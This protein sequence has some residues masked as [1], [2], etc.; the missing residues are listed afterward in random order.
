MGGFFGTVSKASCVTD[1]F[2]GTDYNS[3]LGTKRGGLATYDAEEG[4]FARS[5]HNLESTY[6]RTKFEDELDKF[7][8]NVGIGI[9][10]D[11]DPQPIIINSHLGRFAIVTVAKIVNLEEIEAELLSQ[12]MH[13]AELSSGNTNQTELISL[14]IIQGKTFVE[15]IENVYR[16]VKGSCSMLLLSEDGS[17]I[18]ARDKWGRTPI[19][20]GW[21]EGAYAATSESSSFPN[22][23][24]EIDRYLGPGEIVRMTADGVE[25]LRKPEEKMQ[26]CSFLWVYYGFP[27][28]C[29]EGRNVEEV[30]FTSGLKMGQ[31]DDSEVDCACGIPDSGVGM[32]LGYAEGK[33]VPYHRAIS[34]YTPTWPRSFTP[35]KQEMRSLV[36]KM[37]LIPNRAMLEGKRLLFC[38]DSIVRGTQLRDNVKV[39]YEYGA[40]EVHIR[41]ACPP[42]IYAC[43]F[44]GFTASKSP[45]EL[46]TRRVIEELEGDADKN[47]EKYATTGSPEYE[48]MVSIIAERFGLTT[49]KFNTLET[50]IESIGLPKCKVCTHCFDGSSCF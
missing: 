25:Q 6:F 4:M 46:I 20:I 17:I 14:L 37:K 7:K 13:F 10:S 40:K 15:G 38:D 39:L 16:R 9:I 1:L 24:Y 21:K 33:G 3:H 31:N 43:P 36:A 5:I 34:K 42:L 49:L 11:T 47:L 19:V 8:G 30:R 12:N 26:I 23:D 22:L 50:L 45:L 28:S 41:I 18:A 35:S 44:V 27:T 2:Y 29:Y 32:A 48:K